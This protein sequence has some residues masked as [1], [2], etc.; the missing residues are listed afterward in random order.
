MID[1]QNFRLFA[2]ENNAYAICEGRCEGDATQMSTKDVYKAD[3]YVIYVGHIREALKNSMLSVIN[4]TYHL[5]SRL[6]VK[7]RSPI[8]GGDCSI[9]FHEVSI[10]KIV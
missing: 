6:T 3:I 5:I 8:D 1:C 7:E 2:H 10:P 4:R 9:E